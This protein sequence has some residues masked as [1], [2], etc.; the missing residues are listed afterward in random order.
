MR[1]EKHFRFY[2]ALTKDKSAPLLMI[3]EIRLNKSFVSIW[4]PVSAWI[5]HQSPRVPT[6]H[7]KQLA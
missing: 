5:G 7:D 3:L 2:M 4:N 6:S 1:F